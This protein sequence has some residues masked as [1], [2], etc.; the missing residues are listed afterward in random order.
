F[1]CYFFCRARRGGAGQRAAAGAD[2]WVSIPYNSWRRADRRNNYQYVLGGRNA[3]GSRGRLA[4]ARLYLSRV[5]FLDAQNEI[6]QH[7][8]RKDT[9]TR[10][11]GPSRKE[12]LR[13]GHH[14]AVE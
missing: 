11:S 5:F 10:M 6:F 14:G 8:D 13:I 3:A 12:Q 9:L 4:V 7:P 1:L 2:D